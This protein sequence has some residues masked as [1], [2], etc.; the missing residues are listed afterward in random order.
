MHG[1]SNCRKRR[2]MITLE[3]S[4]Q[5]CVITSQRSMYIEPWLSDQGNENDM[6]NYDKEGMELLGRS[7]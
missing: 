6:R 7:Q 1:T 2:R 3:L 4:T 5:V